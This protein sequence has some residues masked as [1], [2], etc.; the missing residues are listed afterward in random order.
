MKKA[1]AVIAAALLFGG[2]AGGTIVGITHVAGLDASLEAITETE[3]TEQQSEAAVID[4]GRESGSGKEEAVRE[5]KSDLSNAEILDVSDI[6]EEAMP[7]VVSITNTMV[8]KQQ[9]Y[10]SIFDYMYGNARTQEYEV[11]ASGS[12]VI[13]DKTEDELL[14][15][16]NNHVIEDSKELSVTFIDGTTVDANIK[17]AD[18]SIDLAVIAVPIEDISDETM[19][20]IKVAKLHDTEDLK[21]GQGVIA[22]GNALGYGQTVTV[23]YI[24]ALDR[25]LKAENG[26]YSNLIQVDAAINPGNSG[27]ALI[28]MNGEVI[29]INVAKLAQTSVEGMGYSIPI[30]KAKEV[31]DGL[32]AA[33]TRKAIDEK[34][35]GRLGIYMNTVSADNAAALGIPAGVIIRGFSD[36]EIE[37]YDPKDV[38]A[39]PAREAGLRKNDIITK[40]DN[41]AVNSA[42]DLSNLVK[43]YEKGT[44]VDVT[45]QRLEDGTYSEKVITVVLGAKNDRQIPPVTGEE[46]SQADPGKEGAEEGSENSAGKNSDGENGENNTAENDDVYDLFRE[47]LEQYR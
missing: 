40:F 13:L 17:G 43:Y 18:S 25:E 5:E 16:T 30:Y 10:N 15:V 44:S 42:E 21:V 23:G 2:I 14:I 24:S 27:G 38:Q 45:V 37:G 20:K 34:D 19:G 35:Q 22:I 6:V 46:G 1:L 3:S 28:N 11:P 7:Q 39:S 29:G 9:G 26:V 32:S 8:I 4:T 47:F 36:E 33:K 31:I 12:G 41:Q